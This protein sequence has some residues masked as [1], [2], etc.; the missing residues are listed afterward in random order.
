MGTFAVDVAFPRGDRHGGHAVADQ[1]AQRA[2]D[3]HEPV[4]RQ[5]QHQTDGGNRRNRVQ[6]GGQHHDRRARHAVRALGGDQRDRQD[7]QQVGHRDRRVGGL[8]NEHRR[9][10]DV[11]RERVQVERV[12]RGNHQAH[13]RIADAHAAQL[14]HDLRQHAV[15]RGGGEHDGQLFAQVAQQLPEAEARHAHHQPEHHEHEDQHRAVEESDQHAQLLER[16]DAVLADREGNGAQHAQR[17][18]LDDDAHDLEQHQ[19]ERIDHRRHRRTAIAQ[20]RQRAAEQHREQQHLQHVARGEGGHHRG[21][22]E[23]HQELDRA[24][25]GELVGVGGVGAHG[26]GVQRLGVDVHAHARLEHEG[27]HQAHRQRDGGQHLEVDQRL[28]ADPAHALEVA[29][30]GDAMHHHAEHQHGNDHLDQLDEAV[31]QRLELGGELGRKEA[32]EHADHQCDDHLSEERFGKARHGNLLS[33]SCRGFACKDRFFLHTRTVGK[34]IAGGSEGI[35]GA[36]RSTGYP[37]RAPGR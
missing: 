18:Q 20:Q 34:K 36:F 17:R 19:R 2:G 22:N 4:D 25:A 14:G 24:A 16:A 11:D 3:A 26:A 13:R 5:H 33:L 9:Q 12:A 27:Q 31:T 28:H 21:G 29:R 15:R 8:R 7:G 32:D 37:R 23:L 1:V 30:A 6:R 10:R 35:P